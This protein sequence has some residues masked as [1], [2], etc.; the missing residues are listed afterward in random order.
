MK[1]ASNDLFS[2]NRE[3]IKTFLLDQKQGE[4]LFHLLIIYS[5]LDTKIYTLNFVK[6]DYLILKIVRFREKYVSTPEPLMKGYLLHETLRSF[7]R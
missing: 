6:G 3:Q 2:R 7:D 1:E 5:F 4:I